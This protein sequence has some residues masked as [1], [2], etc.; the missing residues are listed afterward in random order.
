MLGQAGSLEPRIANAKG[1]IYIHH[2]PGWHAAAA[3][4]DRRAVGANVGSE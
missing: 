3:Q 4:L 1:W 2:I